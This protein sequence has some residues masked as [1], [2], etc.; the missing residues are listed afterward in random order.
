MPVRSTRS[1]LDVLYDVKSKSDVV[2]LSVRSKPDEVVFYARSK[3]DT[4]VLDDERSK[5]EVLVLDDER[6]KPE[7][8][9]LFARSNTG[10]AV[11][12]VRLDLTRLCRAVRP[13]E[14][15]IE[16]VQR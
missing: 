11:D 8:V 16:C 4:V 7:V 6:S 5:P 3:P 10:Q 1:T 12:G 9:V 15:P 14:Q 13:P 2:V